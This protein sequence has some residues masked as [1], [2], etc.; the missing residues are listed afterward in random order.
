MSD[1]DYR[2]GVMAVF[3]YLT[4]R[5]ANNYHANVKINEECQKENDLVWKWAMDA[6]YDV[7]PEDH[8]EML[9]FYPQYK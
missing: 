7:S 1:K 3:D 5:A 8:D 4:T 9:K 2:R 6:L